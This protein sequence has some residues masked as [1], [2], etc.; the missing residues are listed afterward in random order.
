M[1]VGLYLRHKKTYAFYVE[2]FKDNTDYGKQT[3]LG[4]AGDGTINRYDNFMFDFASP[5][6][7]EFEEHNLGVQEDRAYYTIV[8]PSGNL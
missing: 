7:G 4:I 5:E 2:E 3:Y 8:G 6:L 1:K